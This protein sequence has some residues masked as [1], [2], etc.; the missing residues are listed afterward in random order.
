M[1]VQARGTA[2]FDA[3]GLTDARVDALYDRA[4]GEWISLEYELGASANLVEETPVPEAVAT[5]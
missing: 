4:T 3:E 2:D 5:R 1:R